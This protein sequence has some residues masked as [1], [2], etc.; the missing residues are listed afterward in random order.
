MRTGL[1][2]GE[3]GLYLE[4]L[5]S[6]VV[7]VIGFSIS[8]VSPCSLH[9]LCICHHNRCNRLNLSKLYHS[10]INFTLSFRFIN[11]YISSQDNLNCIRRMLQCQIYFVFPRKDCL[12]ISFHIAL[13]V[14]IFIIMVYSSSSLYLSVVSFDVF[15]KGLYRRLV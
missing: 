5:F 3:I 15:K 12:C 1:V 11:S 6:V 2:E 4:S 10:H 9:K 14:F 7:V 8:N 13:Q